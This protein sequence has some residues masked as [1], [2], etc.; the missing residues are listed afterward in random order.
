M[1]DFQLRYRWLNSSE[2]NSYNGVIRLTVWEIF[3]RCLRQIKSHTLWRGKN[4]FM[5]PCVKI[6]SPPSHYAWKINKCFSPL[7]AYLIAQNQFRFKILRDNVMARSQNKTYSRFGNAFQ[8]KYYGKD[9]SRP[10]WW[11]ELCKRDKA[12]IRINKIAEIPKLWYKRLAINV[13]KC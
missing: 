5:D 3:H 11:I 6:T 12:I 10:F 2:T 13:L 9:I 1:M 4:I 8:I 7:L